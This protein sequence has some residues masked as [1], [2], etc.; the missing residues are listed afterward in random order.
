MS[1]NSYS[2]QKVANVTGFSRADV[3]RARKEMLQEG[4]DWLVKN[5]RV[6]IT[7]SGLDKLLAHF[8]ALTPPAT[9]SAPATKENARKARQRRKAAPSDAGAEK[10]DLVE[11]MKRSAVIAKITRKVMNPRLL[12]GEIDG[13]QIRI[14]VSNA[15]PFLVDMEIPVFQQSQDLYA[16]EGPLPRNGRLFPRQPPHP[17]ST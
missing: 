9:P 7:E 3:A 4:T 6:C 11:R 1:E 10:K 16:Y 8:K 15:A 17:S 5:R 2:E 14:R 13:R 12:L